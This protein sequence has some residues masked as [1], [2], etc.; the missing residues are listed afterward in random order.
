[1]EGRSLQPKRE[2]PTIQIRRSN[3]VGEM[4]QEEEYLTKE[5]EVEE[6]ENELS[7]DVTNVTKW[8][9]DLLNARRRKT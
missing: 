9:I 2:S 8:V 7:L 6:E 1:M 5:V 4:N 3:K